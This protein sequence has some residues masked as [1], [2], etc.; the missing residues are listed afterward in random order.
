MDV[1]QW[2]QKLDFVSK[3]YVSFMLTNIGQV[4][5]QQCSVKCWTQG[6]SFHD[7]N[8]C[9]SISYVRIR[10]LFQLWMIL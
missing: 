10:N 5:A 3:C 2:D 9:V 6:Q 7:F 8:R 4:E 1:L